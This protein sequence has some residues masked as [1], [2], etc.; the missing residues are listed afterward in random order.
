MGKNLKYKNLSRVLGIL[1]KIGKILVTICVP[2]LVI[3]MVFI[4]SLF[5]KVDVKNDKIVINDKNFIL[6]EKKNKV[7]ILYNDTVLGTV[8]KVHMDM[9]QDFFDRNSKTKLV[10]CTELFFGVIVIYLI[11]IRYILKYLENFFYN[12]YEEDTPFTS[13]NISLIK[14]AARTSI[15]AMVLPIIGFMA[16]ELLLGISINLH[17]ELS[18]IFMILFL[19]VLDYIFECGFELQM[20]GKGE[21]E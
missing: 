2:I 5:N 1:A 21:K 9:F 17:I 7:D 20:N 4:P 3:A 10:V 8:D 19:Y 15:I 12:I 6:K 16:I 14:K 18:N 13:D 11:I